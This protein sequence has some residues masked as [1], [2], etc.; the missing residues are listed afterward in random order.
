MLQGAYYIAKWAY[1]NTGRLKEPPQLL[2]L[3]ITR[4]NERQEIETVKLS[5]L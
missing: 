5:N 3:V 2:Q 4:Y 1:K